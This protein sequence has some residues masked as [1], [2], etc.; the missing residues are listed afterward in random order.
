[1]FYIDR[2]SKNWCQIHL[3]VLFSRLML[4]RSSFTLSRGPKPLPSELNCYPPSGCFDLKERES[5]VGG[6]DS[7][8]GSP[9][10]R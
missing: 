4:R 2:I 1:M 9:N 3:R 8:N 7:M 5:E 6:T 10:L